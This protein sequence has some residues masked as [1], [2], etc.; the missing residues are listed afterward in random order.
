MIQNSHSTDLGPPVDVWSLG[1]LLYA[2]VCGNLPFGS[3][4]NTKSLFKRI[5]AGKYA[6]NAHLTPGLWRQTMLYR[7]CIWGGFV[8]PTFCPQIYYSGVE[9]LLQI[10]LQVE[11]ANRANVRVVAAHPWLSAGYDSP[12]CPLD[13]QVQIPVHGPL[14]MICATGSVVLLLTFPEHWGCCWRGNCFYDGENGAP[15]NSKRGFFPCYQHAI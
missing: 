6:P 13:P 9:S 14:A 7:R 5:L 12:P 3:G 15:F 8:K 11:V 10:M 1:V 2:C 4:S